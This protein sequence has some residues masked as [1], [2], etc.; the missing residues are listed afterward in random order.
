MA[1]LVLQA[2]EAH[3]N[4]NVNLARQLLAQALIQN[5]RDEGAWMMMAELVDDVKL[6]RNCLQRVLLINPQNS[7]ANIALMKLDTSPLSPVVRGERYKPIVPPQAEKAPPF[8]PPFTW[9]EE[10]N[11]YQALGDMTYPNLEEE[12]AEPPAEAPPSFDWA[13]ESAEPDKTIDKIFEAVSNP[14]L[15]SQPLPDSDLSWVEQAKPAEE[16]ASDAAAEKAPVIEAEE[17]PGTPETTEQALPTSPQ[18]F[19]VS[20][21]SEWG[22]GAFAPAESSRDASREPVSFLWDNPRA[23]IDRLVILGFTSVIFANPAPKDV[24]EITRLFK[25]SKMVRELLGKEAGVIK[26]ENIQRLSAIPKRAH[27]DIEYQENGKLITHPLVFKDKRTRDEA[28]AAIK[29]RLGGG[30][31]SKTQTVSGMRRIGWPVV[32][33]LIFAILG[34]GLTGGVNLLSRLPYFQAGTPLLIVYNIQYYVDLFGTYYVLAI[35]GI[36][37]L[38]CLLWLMVNL[39]KPNKVMILEKR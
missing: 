33:A 1:E 16:A 13:T 5:P 34:W 37:T 25:E 3:K 18:D 7:A 8:T 9:S 35:A 23:K 11:Q 6:K 38:L 31:H 14:E 12:Q 24:A 39:S 10:D 32:C 15:A 36:A 29:L 20:A 27:L 2:M 4:G 21:E 19:E 30:F 17:S 28:L 26:L 22:L